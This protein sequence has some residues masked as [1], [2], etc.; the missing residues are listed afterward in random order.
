MDPILVILFLTNRNQFLFIYLF[1]H[2]V[3][4]FFLPPTP[5]CPHTR[6]HHPN[7]S[8]QILCPQKLKGVADPKKCANFILEST[9]LAEDNYRLGNTKAWMNNIH[10]HNFLVDFLLLIFFCVF[11]F[12]LSLNHSILWKENDFKKVIFE[13]FF[14]KK[15]YENQIVYYTD[16]EFGYW[17]VVVA[18]NWMNMKRMNATFRS[19]FFSIFWLTKIIVDNTPP[20]KLRWP[21]F[22]EIL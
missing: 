12:I 9:P 22:V 16:T 1:I 13:D 3:L 11:F 17:L 18:K 5:L 4:C 14:K 6:T 7:F 15:N 2:Y 8:Y 19:I 20:E 10:L 21:V